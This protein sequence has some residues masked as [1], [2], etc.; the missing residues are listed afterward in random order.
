MTSLKPKS[1][2]QRG[3]QWAA[4]ALPGQTSA[5]RGPAWTARYRMSDWE[6][7]C[8][9]CVE[10]IV[11]NVRRSRPHPRRRVEALVVPASR[12]TLPLHSVPLWGAIQRLHGGAGWEA[13][14]IGIC[15]Q[16]I[17]IS[18]SSSTD[19]DC[20]STISSSAWKRQR[21]H[22]WPCA[23][24]TSCTSWVVPSAGT[25][26][27]WDAK[28]AGLAWTWISLTRQEGQNLGNHPENSPT[29]RKGGTR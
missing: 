3:W 7:S 20:M 13:V 21:R 5:T 22:S 29:R 14:L 23:L 10:D 28:C 27:P 26:L 12:Q 24:A 17:F 15:H 1:V 16:F 19:C 11:A 2:V 6:K 25:R 8:K 18:F 9:P 4:S